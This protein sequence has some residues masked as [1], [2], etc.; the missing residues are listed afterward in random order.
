[1]VFRVTGM[2]EENIEK[3]LKYA[4]IP[5]TSRKESR[6]LNAYGFGQFFPIYLIILFV[7]LL[8]KGEKLWLQVSFI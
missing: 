4:E 1:M 7:I 3:L 8:V 2:R 5:T 6:S